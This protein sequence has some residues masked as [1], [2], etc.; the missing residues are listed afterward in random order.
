MMSYHSH[1]SDPNQLECP[2]CEAL[3]SDLWEVAPREEGEEAVV[4]CDHCGQDFVLRLVDVQYTYQASR[5]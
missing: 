1:D 4:A 5:A 3:Q 2:Y